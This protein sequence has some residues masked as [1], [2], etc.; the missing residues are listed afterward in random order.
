MLF[1][2]ATRHPLRIV[3]AGFVALVLLVLIVFSLPIAELV[4]SVE[5]QALVRRVLY[6][7]QL[8]FVVALLAGTALLI[9]LFWRGH[10]RAFASCLALAVPLVTVYC[11][12][13]FQLRYPH[14][15]LLSF[16]R[17]K[18]GFSMVLGTD[19]PLSRFKPVSTLKTE[20]DLVERAAYPAIDVH[21]HLESLPPNIDADRLVAA[22]DAAGVDKIVNLG[23]LPGGM[24]EGFAETHYAKYPNRFILFA[25]PDPA[26]LAR[27]GGIELDIEWIKKAARLGARGLKENKSFG[28]SQ[29]DASGKIVPVDDPRLAPVWDLAGALGMPVL[30][31]TAEPPSFWEPVDPSNERY[32]ELLENPSWSLHGTQAPSLEELMRQR[33]RLLARH[34]QTNFIGAHFGMNPEDLDYVAYLL[35]NHPNYYVD[36]SSVIQE[37]GRQPYSARR[38][39]IRY[40]DRILFGTDGGFGLVAEGDGWTPERMYRSHFEF[41]ETDNEYIEYPLADITK[42]GSWRVYGLDLPPEVLRKL[43]FENAS[44]LIPSHEEVVRRLD[45]LEAG[46]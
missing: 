12:Y 17:Y 43:Y 28:M 8:L 13:E 14:A 21:F 9:W 23:G 20:R 25:K 46:G 11:A 27:D 30:I 5:D 39:F 32:L 37:L 24:F 33:E 4:S 42:Q 18:D 10:R 19:A 45:A 29:R 44:R 36:M 1:A 41:L 6:R 31:H 38:F 15:A 7:R 35:D 16:D 22:M 34:R 2:A 3:A 40:Q 26:A